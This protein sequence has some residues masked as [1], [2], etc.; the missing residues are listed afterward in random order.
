MYDQVRRDAMVKD[1]RFGARRR[2]GQ[3]GQSLIVAVIVL[4][5]LLFLGG[6]FVALV[7][8][9]LFNAQRAGNVS[10]A[11]GLAEAGLRYLDEQ[12]MTSPEGADWRPV[13]DG[14]PVGIQPPAG[15]VPPDPGD[16]DYFWI[17]P[18]EPAT[19]QGGFTRVIFGGATPTQGNSGGRALVRVTYQPDPRNP[20][21]KYLRLDSVGRVGVI[22]PQDPTTFG[23]TE[24][25]GLRRE[26]VAYKAIGILDY[27]RSIWN[28]DNKPVNAA[29]G[30]PF[31]VYDRPA[32]GN[33]GPAEPRAIV[34]EYVGPIRV[35]GNLLWYGVNRISLNPDRNDAIEVAGN[36]LLN[37]ETPGNPTLV[38]A[39][40]ARTNAPFNDQSPNVFPS[41]APNFST[42]EGVVR[43]APAGEDLSR[44]GGD[45]ADYNN[46]NLRSVARLAPP[47]IDAETGPGGLT[48]YRA[49]TRSS[50]P[51][52]PRW[53]QANPIPPNRYNYAGAYGWGT[54]L[55]IINRDDVQQESRSLAGTYSLRSD[56][57]QPNL[58]GGRNSY[59]RGDFQYEPPAVT[60]ELQPRYMRLTQSTYGEQRRRPLFRAPDGDRI[61]AESIIR[62]TDG[63]KP[64]TDIAAGVSESAKY[65][66]YPEGDY[67]IFAEGNIRIRGTVGGSDPSRPQPYIRHLTVVSNGTIYIDGSLLRDNLQQ[68]QQGRGLSSIALLARDYVAVN[69]TQFLN[70]PDTSFETV[71]NDLVR[72]LDATQQQFEFY[73]TPTPVLPNNVLSTAT[74]LL[75]LRHTAA[76][77]PTSQ[78]GGA[79]INLF[80]NGD[81]AAT[82]LFNFGPPANQT[83]HPVPSQTFVNEVFPLNNGPINL[84]DVGV[85][86]LL[87]F[88]YDVSA[89]STT[90]YRATRIGIAPLDVR[91]EAFIYAQEGSFFIIP[92][93][94]FN[95][96]PNDTYANYFSEETLP[97]GTTRQRLRRAGENPANPDAEVD[98]HFPF[99]REPMDVRL[100][101]YGTVA[102]N[103]P[104]QIGDQGAWLEKWGW[105][106]RFYG[107]TGLP[108]IDG[109]TPP[110]R[111]LDQT[112]HEGVGLL[113]EF[114]EQAILPYVPGTMTPI[115]PDEY[116][117]TLPIVPRLPVAQGLLYSGENPV[118]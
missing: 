65:Q 33:A 50:A 39:Y 78:A 93:P 61:P 24:A 59:W 94:W 25:L 91:I 112:E 37:N 27:V 95:P 54:G 11:G 45:P 77:D 2:G 8:R 41:D 9:N 111:D 49:L 30:A 108:N 23:N 36:I 66:G 74:P 102:E 90:A 6:I 60:I 99:Y 96:D 31:R 109:I 26:L 89:G 20:T 38:T 101:I 110:Q 42:L 34:S 10:S 18:Y 22:N 92:G 53:T 115:R 73:L 118:R 58:S 15:Y 40:D 70:P 71:G 7:A 14:L 68:G 67:V 76:F 29:L 79:F 52:A 82:N 1:K 87:T 72:K 43:D 88:N 5:L 80:V 107:S 17:K 12:L 56:W 57:L 51:M 85:N 28:K 83:S 114:N 98:P 19:G 47:V 116:G 16:P 35:N 21:S 84:N 64:T 113:F 48:R 100:T 75:F 86:N 32:N 106:P 105:T 81:D 97:D 104:A 13:P 44:L 4:F 63:D 69:T 3:A 62:Y 103:L 46:R 55:Y 117:R